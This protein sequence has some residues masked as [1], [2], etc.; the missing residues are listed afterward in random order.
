MYY[1]VKIDQMVLQK[2]D[3]RC[4]FEE[5]RPLPSFRMLLVWF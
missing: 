4:E 2:K 3:R 5:L 1:Q